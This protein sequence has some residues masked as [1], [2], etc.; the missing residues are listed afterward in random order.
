MVKDIITFVFNRISISHVQYE[1][2]FTIRNIA[3]HNNNNTYV[4]S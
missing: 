1:Y 4:A 3:Q 2:N